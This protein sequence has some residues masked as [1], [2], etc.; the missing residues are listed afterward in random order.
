MLLYPEHTLSHNKLCIPVYFFTAILHYY[1]VC[2]KSP[3]LSKGHFIRETGLRIQNNSET[4]PNLEN[5]PKNHLF[6]INFKKKF[7]VNL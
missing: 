4:D 1:T 3:L 2:K 7:K 6:L 5:P